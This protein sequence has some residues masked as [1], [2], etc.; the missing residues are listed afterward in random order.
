VALILAAMGLYGVT[1]YSV[2]QR[3]REIGIRV[4]V[5]AGP[6]HVISMVLLQGVKLAVI[7]IA[8]GILCASSLAGLMKAL[9]FGVPAGDPLTY[10]L[11]SSLLSLVTLAACYV[12]ARSALRIDPVTALRHE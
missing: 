4:A 7:G 10:L 6:R 3:T 8:L 2:E 9:L 1:A 12:P 5:G 11:V